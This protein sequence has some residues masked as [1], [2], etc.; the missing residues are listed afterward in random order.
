MGTQQLLLFVLVAIIV[1]VAIA[2]AVVY[3]KSNQQD[4]DINEVINE[5]N[6]IA[7]TAQG[8]YRKPPTMGGG[9]RSFTGFTLAT[10][11]QP[12][13]TDLAKY[14][15]V[16]A[17]SGLLQLQAIGYLNFT[18]AVNVYPDSIGSFSVV[19]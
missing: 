17:N 6:H 5:L 16:S 4:T 9:N 18:V 3:F 1:A 15:V 10:I 8:W 19:R 12:D 2:L 7:A 11:S 13:S 14:Q